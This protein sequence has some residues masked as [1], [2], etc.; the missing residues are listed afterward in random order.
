MQCARLSSQGYCSEWTL[1]CGSCNKC[2]TFNDCPPYTCM[3]TVQ[4]VANHMLT[5]HP[6]AHHMQ[7]CGGILPRHQF[8]IICHN[9]YYTLVLGKGTTMQFHCLSV[10]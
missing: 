3:L 8:F 1:H 7:R 4:P 2:I 6:V 5:V 9:T 10:V